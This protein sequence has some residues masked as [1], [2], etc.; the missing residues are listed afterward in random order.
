LLLRPPIGTTISPAASASRSLPQTATSAI[1]DESDDGLLIADLADPALRL[2]YV[3]PAFERITAYPREE[4]IGKNCR[5]LQGSDR[6]QPEIAEIRAAIGALE[7]VNVTLRNYRKDG[8]LFW[9]ELRLLPVF[10]DEN[11]ATH[12]VGIVRDV[13]AARGMTDQLHRAEHFDLLTG[14]LNRYAFL[15]KLDKL[16]D[17]NPMLPLVVKIDVA[18]LDEI[19]SGYGHETGDALLEQIARRLDAIG[20]AL[21]ARTGGNEFAVACMFDR[22]EQAEA[23]LERIG[24]VLR[25]RYALPGAHL[26]VRFAT[27][28]TVGSPGTDA[29]SLVRQAGTALHRSKANR[30]RE[31]QRFEERDV[32]HAR[33]HLRLTS[34]LQHA[35]AENEF[36]LYY[37]PK[38]ELQ[39]GTLVGAEALLRWNHGLFGVQP[40]DRFIG[41]AEETGL[42]LDIGEW[43]RRAVARFAT[44]VNRTRATPIR[45]SLNVST[46]ELTHGDL[47]SSVARAIKESGAD[48]AWLTLELTET[49]MAE[50]TPA[51]L[52]LFKRLRDLGV[53]LSV[54]DFGMGYSNLRYID[55]F[56]LSEIKIDK[57]FI[58]DIQSNPTKQIIVAAMVDIGRELGL[59]IVA[60]GIETDA[61]RKMLQSMK[62]PYGQGF[63]LGRPISAND[64]RAYVG[65]G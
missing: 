55:R 13:T 18:H 53:G 52:T 35:V 10:D 12:Y 48:P 54:D 34:E 28:Y 17:G 42:I 8:S 29:L 40:P 11:R 44:E 30:L 4:A 25:Q 50:D 6:L 59:D 16:L 39:S 61:E 36:L 23:W 7:P 2:T 56:P 41:V 62:C 21:V 47:V 19:N 64:F 3:N 51:L 31:T 46:I 26:V 37:Q 9:N 22:D 49:L 38:F 60:E 24:T 5:Y 45:F 57:H 15:H 43:G 1:M 20:A 33:R 63:L 32:L 27:G 65:G 58:R 14:S